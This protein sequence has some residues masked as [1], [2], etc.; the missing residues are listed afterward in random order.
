MMERGL[1]DRRALPFRRFKSDCNVKENAT[2]LAAPRRNN[3]RWR[4]IRRFAHVAF[5]GMRRKKPHDSTSIVWIA[6]NGM[7]RIDSRNLLKIA[8]SARMIIWPQDSRRVDVIDAMTAR[9]GI[10]VLRMEVVCRTDTSKRAHRAAQVHVVTRHHHAPAI[11]A[12]S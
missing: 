3:S 6:Q 9:V 5:M 7:N 2:D 4:M 1:R 12:K 11:L 10:G 8:V